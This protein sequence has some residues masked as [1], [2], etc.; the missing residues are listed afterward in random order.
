MQLKLALALVLLAATSA[1]ATAILR[2]D[3]SAKDQA[4]VASV[5]RPATDFSRPE[6]FEAMPAGAATVLKPRD[7]NA[8]SH[9]SANLSLDDQQ[10]FVVGNGLFRKEWI[11]APS[12]TQASDG[13]GPLFN[14]RACQSCHIKDG[15][16]HAPANAGDDAVSLLLR[17]SIPPNG[18]QQSAID[19]GLLTAVPEPTYGSQLQDF[20]VAGLA[21]EGQVR[22]AYEEFPA[23]LSGGETV[24]LRKPAVTIGNLGF[25][26][27]APDFMLSA[28]IAPPMGGMGLLDAIHPADIL[29]K[30]DPD[31]A[32]GDGISGRPNM[33][34]DGRG[35]LTIGRFGWKAV[36]PTV[37]QQTAHAFAGDMGLSTP[38]LADH[39]GDC[40][41][42]EAACRS[43]PH[44][45]QADFGPE[46]VPRDLLDFV[47]FYSENLALPARPNSG[48][49][50]V[51][52]GK[53]AFYQ[54]GCPSCHVPKYVTSRN[55]AHEA[56]RFQLIW[57]YTDLLLHDMG[58][59]LA[60]NRPEGQATGREW[61]TPPLWGIGTATTISG[62][63]G[64]LHDGRARTLKEAILW[65][66]G[67]AQAARDSFAA[68]Q[69]DE[70]DA[71]IRFLESL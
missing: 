21:A 20:A 10:R 4:K 8:L 24:I 59:E 28:R 16:G 58:A 47:T 45:A 67:E 52:N 38:I 33:V 12:S 69:R 49:T 34:G 5:T 18:K 31:D 53:K 7:A 3:L 15:R 6:A 32:N 61:R 2:D 70:R 1:A 30:A 57:P 19:A 17:I 46:E 9:P 26:P 11:S 41:E 23:S 37:E 13:L 40:G 54:A 25:G 29:A 55:A 63:A 71:L 64:F 39:W 43:M 27:L 66:G 60:D 56:H 65:H 48:N 44:G 36:Q 35:G 50:T 14:A 51:L 62:E 68:M 22:I 42:A